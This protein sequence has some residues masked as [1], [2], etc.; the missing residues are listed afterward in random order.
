MESNNVLK[1]IKL[2]DVKSPK[3]AHSDDAGIDFFI[4]NDWIDGHSFSLTP[5]ER[6]LIPSGIKA[7]VP[8]GHA[9]IF[10]NKS[11]N[12]SKLGLDVLA[13]T[14]DE[15][16]EGEINLNVVNTSDSVVVLK[17]GMK[18]L[19]GILLPINYANPLEIKSIEELYDGHNSSRKESGFGSSGI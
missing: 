7:R 2:R 16:Y 10:F 12:A 18:L 3:R 5:H 19:Q 4:P 8:T 15:N 14:V 17:G 13:N 9:L 1:F 6:I 11:G